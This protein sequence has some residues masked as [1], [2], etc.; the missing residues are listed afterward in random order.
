MAT[1]PADISRALAVFV[2]NMG[3]G[4]DAARALA[5]EYSTTGSAA[6]LPAWL[7]EQIDEVDAPRAP[8]PPR[9]AR[10]LMSK[11]R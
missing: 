5:D 9:S 10:S 1:L 2:A 7:T 11:S 8:R 3:L 4:Q 6:D